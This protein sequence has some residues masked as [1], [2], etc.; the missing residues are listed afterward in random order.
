MISR[1]ITID[2]LV[3]YVYKNGLAHSEQAPHISKEID[4][5]SNTRRKN[6]SSI[7]LSQEK[8]TFI[9]NITGEGLIL[10]EWIMNIYV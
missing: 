10:L 8:E 3:T 4:S 9:K 2:N 5:K 1:K 6:A 7:Q